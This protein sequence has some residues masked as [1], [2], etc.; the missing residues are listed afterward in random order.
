MDRD[1]LIAF[2]SGVALFLLNLWLVTVLVR[3]FFLRRPQTGTG[4]MRLVISLVFILKT[5]AVG[6]SAY[7]VVVVFKLPPIAFFAGAFVGL[8]GYS[9]ISFFMRSRV[10]Q[11]I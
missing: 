10:L 7:L 11:N 2:S 3:A 8:S 1:N 4:P 9:L 5:L 6:L